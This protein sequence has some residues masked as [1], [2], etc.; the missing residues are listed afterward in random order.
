M[1]PSQTQTS[2]PLLGQHI[3]MSFERHDTPHTELSKS[4]YILA[5]ALGT[6]VRPASTSPGSWDAW[7]NVDVF[8]LCRTVLSDRT[9]LRHPFDPLYVLFDRSKQREYVVCARC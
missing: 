5:L 6:A 9:A 1:R 3:G 7:A 2:F 8:V 4:K